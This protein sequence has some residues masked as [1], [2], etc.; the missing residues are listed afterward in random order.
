MPQWCPPNAKLA[1]VAEHIIAGRLGAVLDPGDQIVK[2]GLPEQ[3]LKLR[4]GCGTA[5]RYR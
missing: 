3:S 1:N 5:A 4:Q 2:R